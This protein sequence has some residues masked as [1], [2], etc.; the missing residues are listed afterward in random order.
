MIFNTSFEKEEIPENWK[1]VIVTA[2]FKKSA[3]NY[4][5]VSLTSILCKIKEK[6]IRKRIIEHMDRQNSVSKQQFG[7][8]GGRSTSA[9][10]PKVLNNGG[11]EDPYILC[12]NQDSPKLVC[13]PTTIIQIKD[14]IYGRTVRSVCSTSNHFQST[15]CNVTVTSILVSNC[16][17]LQT[18][19]PN[20]LNNIY[21][22]PC[23][24]TYK[25]LNVTYSQMI[26][27]FVVDERI[28]SKSSTQLPTLFFTA[29]PSSIPTTEQQELFST[30][31]SPTSSSKTE[32]QESFST[33]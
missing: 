12:E 20:A 26:V 32:Q 18:C 2:L 5:P 33:T 1:I 15:S 25:Y 4:R 3:S 21:G 23:H 19:L 13:P 24:G 29:S 16:S 27:Q 9:E 10:S 28:S 17:N 22:D 31:A 8:M 11:L 7:S 14:A 6:L 30:T